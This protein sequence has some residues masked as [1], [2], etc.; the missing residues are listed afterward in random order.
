MLRRL[1]VRIIFLGPLSLALVTVSGLPALPT[2][3]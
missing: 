2:Q 3:R 1:V